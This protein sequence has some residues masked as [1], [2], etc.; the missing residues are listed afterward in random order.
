MSQLEVYIEGKEDTMRKKLSTV[1]LALLLVIQSFIGSAPLGYAYTEEPAQNVAGENQDV[2]NPAGTAPED[3]T[4]LDKAATDGQVETSPLPVQEKDD[5]KKVEANVEPAP[6]TDNKTNATVAKVKVAS[7]KTMAAAGQVI[8]KSILTD[9]VVKDGAGNN[10]EDI[11]VDQGSKVQI[12]YKWNLPAGHSYSDGAIFTFNLPDKF[13]TDRTLTGDLDGEVG[14]YEVTPDGIVT[15]TFNDSINDGTPLTG[16]FFVWREFDMN[17]FSGSTKQLIQFDIKTPK[18]ITVQF[19]NNA[20]EMDKIGSSNKG[21]NPSEINW[22]V[23]FNKGEKSI[24][25]ATFTDKLPSGLEIDMDSIKVYPLTV[26]LNGTVSEGTDLSGYTPKKTDVGFELEFGD[27]NSAYRVKY[28]TKVTSTADQTFQNEATV[29][30]T[31]YP[32]ITET[33]SVPVKFSKPL[34]K[35]SPAYDSTTQTITWAIQYNYNEQ[36]IG[37]GQAMITDTFDTAHQELIDDSFD[38]SEMTIDDNGKA[39]KTGTALT[40]GT[41]YT[42]TSTGTG[43]TLTFSKDVTSAYEISYK[44]KAKSRVNEDN[45]TVDNT[46]EMSDGTKKSATRNIGQV[47]F[48]KGAGTVDY[49]KKTIEWKIWLNYDNKTMDNVTITDSFL[50]QNLKLLEDS[51]TISGLT[52]DTD[53]TLEPNNTYGEGL[54]IT[55]KKPIT[56]GHYITYKTEFDPRQPIPSGGYKNN[57]TLNWDENSTKQT[58]ITK[59]AT[60]TPDSYTNKNGNKTGTYNAQTKEITW[61][62]DVNYNFHTIPNAVLSDFY[63]GEQ[64]FVDGSL[65]VNK[66]DLTGGTNGVNLGNPVTINE[67]DFSAKKDEKG[68]DGFE[69]KLGDIDSAY[70]ITYKTSLKGHPVLK[71]YSNHATLQGE[72]GSPVFDQSAIVN[73]K[74]GGEYINKTG[75]QGTGADSEFAFWTVNINRSQSHIDAGAKLTDTLS[76]NQILIKDSINLYETKVATNGTLTKD[77][78]NVTDYTLNVTNNVLELTFTKDIDRSYILEYKSFINADNGEKIS[79]NVQFAGQS[80]GTVDKNDK[81][82]VDV[83][84]SGAGGGADTPG[85]GKFK[86]VKVDADTKTPLAGA[87]FGLYDKSG[88]TLLETLVTD[89][90]GEAE[91]KIYKFK[92]YKL[93]ELSAPSGYAIA[94]EYKV[95][96]EITFKENDQIFTVTNKPLRQAVELTKVDKDNMKVLSGAEFE[97]Q[98]K[99]GTKVNT[100]TTD[101]NGQ[102]IVN[103]LDPGDYQFIETKAPEHYLLDATP[104]SFTIIDDQTE[105][106]KINKEN[107]RGKGSLTIKKVDATDETKVLQGAEF[108][109]YD[110]KDQLVTTK[111]TDADG[112]VVFDNL[113][114]DHYHLKE[115]K[116]PSGYAIDISSVDLPVQLDQATKELTIK[117]N[118]IIHAFQLVKVDEANS[119]KVL[120]NAEFKLMYKE[121]KA[122]EYTVVNEKDHLVTD[123]NGLIYEENLKPGFYQLIETKAPVG[124]L[125]DKTPVEFIIENEQIKVLELNKTN[126][127]QPT[128][129]GG[130]NPSKGSLIIKKVDAVDEKTVLQGAEFELYN[131]KNQLVAT[132]TTDADG[133]I[134]FENLPYDQYTLKETKAPKG[135]TIDSVSGNM[136]VNIDQ[137]TK[138]LT[139]KN[140]KIIQAF[141]LTKVDADQTNKVLQ[142]AEFK[143]MYKENKAE[144][145]TAVV[146]D[147]KERLITDEK[148][149]IYEDHLKP[150][151]YQLIETKAP[152]NYLLDETPIDFTIEKEQT[153]VVQLI[154][155]NKQK[156]TDG[157]GEKPDP[158]KPNKPDKPGDQGGDPGDSDKPGDQ[159]NSGDSDKPGDQGNS[160]NTNDPGNQ[161]N[162]GNP[163][164]PDN[165]GNTG[166]PNNIN[167]ILPQTGEKAKIGLLFAGLLFTIIGVWILLYRRKTVE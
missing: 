166:A 18:E 56:T 32:A 52:K 20:S 139:I 12:D 108:E 94:S 137:T 131:G 110:S 148:G 54:K 65:Q 111:T 4:N 163:N 104:V 35:T 126:K 63:T 76:E 27:I 167:E 155:E 43:F 153:K 13:K 3:S 77:K 136:P 165:P 61:T 68:N 70:R 120:K 59:S 23:D 11:R 71:S 57:A 106:V 24:K 140:S 93:K 90:N 31:D 72:V 85:K 103:E 101:A 28:T 74:F 138:E 161:G 73:P 116:A 17:K 55:F 141:Q 132:K 29:L 99:D 122:D 66:L 78:V 107:E 40:K 114:Y 47:I 133:K 102:I 118:K 60:V 124:Y 134:V 115:T 69:L 151:Y 109:L 157:D 38:V 30:G 154:K 6:T 129:G 135:Y 162:V 64:T 96:K 156:P 49:N 119:K 22:V 8:E 34:A 88:I 160:D 89:E 51:L 82:E 10:I 1:A 117:N 50:G 15:F 84:F 112:K 125:L 21:M 123:D 144:E 149:I 81:K 159:E 83:S 143:L 105:V 2:E 44:T 19:K 75:K 95:G 150:G 127:Q 39:T 45:Y 67:E 36:V 53:Y 62:I 98:K 14:T 100:H 128:G 145:Y 79:N 113:P 33:A 37:Q 48:Q 25:G 147:G 87:K 80:S 130:E 26:N 7:A 164:K 16:D 92:I 42:V 91:S 158:E 5:N 86:I 9:V 41:D 97:L 58:P 152:T 142:G 46:V 146:V 121:T